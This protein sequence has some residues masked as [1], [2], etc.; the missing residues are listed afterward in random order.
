MKWRKSK[1]LM[2][3]GLTSCGRQDARTTNKWLGVIKWYVDFCRWYSSNIEWKFYWS[4]S[5]Y[6]LL[7]F[8]P[9]RSEIL[10]LLLIDRSE[11]DSAK[12]FT[13]SGA[14]P[15]KMNSSCGTDNVLQFDNLNFSDNVIFHIHTMI[16]HWYLFLSP[17]AFYVPLQDF[18]IAV[19]VTNLKKNINVQV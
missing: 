15:R 12:Y 5:K 9:L 13:R 8:L 18:K 6:S 7:G 4:R 2:P 17:R 3:F 1:G 10:Y 14:I 16:C 11:G 19:S